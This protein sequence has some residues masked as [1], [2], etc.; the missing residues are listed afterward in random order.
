[1]QSY[2]FNNKR[3]NAFIIITLIAQII[4][5]F[6][7]FLLGFLAT[8]LV[9]E[10]FA[11]LMK[12]LFNSIP[13]LILSLLP[14]V[15]F[16]LHFV[17]LNKE[18]KIKKFFIPVY[19]AYSA[20]NPTLLVIASAKS[21]FVNIN[22][23]FIL[24]FFGSFFL[25]L[26]SLTALIFLFIGSLNNFKFLKLFR[27]GALIYIV[28]TVCVVISSFINLINTPIMPSFSNYNNL[29]SYINWNSVIKL[30]ILILFYVGLFLLTF[31]KEKTVPTIDK[32]TEETLKINE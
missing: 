22:S 9:T 31:N 5:I 10:S 3:K 28:F 15:I 27:T 2:L 29:I 24:T 21:F 8:E 6:A 4:A 19:F 18:S 26:I 32:E 11:F 1:M 17:F 25:N 23:S 7:D 13:S 12:T 14:S 20:I 30:I 16:I